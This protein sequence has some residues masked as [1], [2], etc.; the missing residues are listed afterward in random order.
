M[1]G[2]STSAVASKPL[3]SLFVWSTSLI[4]LR[5]LSRS[6]GSGIPWSGHAPYKKWRNI[7]AGIGP[8][9]EI[10]AMETVHTTQFAFRFLD[11]MDDL[12]L[13]GLNGKIR[14]S[15]LPSGLEVRRH[16]RDR[17]HTCEFW[18]ELPGRYEGGMDAGKDTEEFVS[19]TWKW[20]LGGYGPTSSS[21]LPHPICIDIAAIQRDSCT[22]IG[23]DVDISITVTVL[24]GATVGNGVMIREDLGM[25]ARRQWGGR[26]ICIWLWVTMCSY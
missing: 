10:G 23:M 1:I 19:G 11:G 12:R 20:R 3:K 26:G 5:R 14:M 22:V 25:S 2:G 21:T 7:T 18:T 4:K 17:T 8:S 9:A 6:S 13:S 15:L 24:R 16:L